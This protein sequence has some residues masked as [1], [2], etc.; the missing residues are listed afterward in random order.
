MVG[1][2]SLVN[3]SPGFIVFHTPFQDMSSLTALVL[4]TAL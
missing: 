1:D 4:T 3:V 2:S